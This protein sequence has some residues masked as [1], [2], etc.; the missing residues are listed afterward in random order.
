MSRKRY[1]SV[2]QAD[3]DCCYISGRTDALEWHH[4]YGGSN[5]KYSE[6]YGFMIRLNHH[7]H[8]EPP[9]GVHHNKQFMEY[10]HREGQRLFEELYGTRKEFYDVFG[11]Y[12]L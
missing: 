2:M 8:N 6:Q 4:V 1:K 7:Y 10:L 12:Y 11:R 9:M 5:K 3:T